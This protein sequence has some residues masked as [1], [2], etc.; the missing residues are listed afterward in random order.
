L[1]R[2]LILGWL[3]NEPVVGTGCSGF[4]PRRSPISFQR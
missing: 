2:E 3:L 1:H 4:E